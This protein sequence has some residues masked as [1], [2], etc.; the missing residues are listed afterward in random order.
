MAT[1]VHPVE[2]AIVHELTG[3]CPMATH[4]HPE[5]DTTVH[6]LSGDCPCGPTRELVGCG[7]G[8]FRWRIV[9][10]EAGGQPA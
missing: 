9:H 10:H 1:H 2:D 6:V 5:E 7:D 4:V 8:M 3:A